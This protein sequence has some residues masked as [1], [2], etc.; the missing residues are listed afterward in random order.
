M[1][2]RKKNPRKSNSH[3]NPKT[4]N[5]VRKPDAVLQ[6]AKPKPNEA[7][8]IRAGFGPPS[9]KDEFLAAEA[10]AIAADEAVPERDSRM[11]F[12]EIIERRH[13]APAAKG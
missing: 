13:S 3:P 7:A 1:D 8:S 2:R 4:E 11:R 9:I 6:E 12:K 5:E 10:T